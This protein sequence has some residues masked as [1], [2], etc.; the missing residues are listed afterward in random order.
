MSDVTIKFTSEMSDVIRDFQATQREILKTNRALQRTV[1][2][3]NRARQGM[4]GVFGKAI[5][6]ARSYAL[7]LVG[8][9]GVVA[10]INAVRE[11]NKAWMQ[12][13]AEAGKA[14]DESFRKFRIQSGLRGLE[15]EKAQASIQRIAVQFPMSDTPVVSAADAARQL[16]SSGFSAG[17]GS[18]AALTEFSK[19][20]GAT[21]ATGR[22]V[23]VTGLAKVV[24]M[25]LS[26]Q[27][28]P[29][30][31]ANLGRV[32]QNI[33]SLFKGTNI[34][35]TDMQEFAGI[36]SSLKSA[37][38]SP[39]EQFAMFSTMVQG[40]GAPEAA[41][42]MRNII[43]RMTT[44][45][46]SDAKV[47]ALKQ[48]G[49]KPSDID[50]VGEDAGTALTTLRDALAKQS[51]EQQAIIRTK[52]FEE[53][54]QAQAQFLMESLDLYQQ[55][56]DIQRGAGPAYA[57]DVQEAFGGRVMAGRRQQGEAQ[58][59]AANRDQLNDLYREQIKL[60]GQQLGIMPIEIARRQGL[61]S[62]GIGFGA[63]PESALKGSIG[64]QAYVDLI[65]Q[66]VYD[67]LGGRGSDAGRAMSRDSAEQ[68]KA[69]RDIARN[70]AKPSKRQTPRGEALSGNQSNAAY[71]G[72]Q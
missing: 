48:I 65:E 18:G 46:G 16:V 62:A 1:A 29:M 17:E 43:G 39:E 21:A 57:A 41:T 8:V 13:S 55:G 19:L 5:E 71:R 61:Y 50:L 68:T 15:G 47:K 38:M 4:Q 35:V 22:E 27:Q 66:S 42:G 24:S 64:N 34:Q 23:D 60:T 45:G 3:G 54:G 30:T 59:N 28:M 72:P 58:I 37:G 6:G 14:L 12:E 36:A 7:G 31:G 33:Q 63:S 70:T 53:R 20:M 40:Y 69:L 56:L 26:S 51:P 11:T 9:G 10:A 44:A 25:Y 67:K 52:L 2:D 32:S 49:L